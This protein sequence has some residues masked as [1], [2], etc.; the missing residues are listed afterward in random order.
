MNRINQRSA[1]NRCQQLLRGNQLLIAK[2]RKLQ[3][4]IAKLASG[5]QS[6]VAL[7]PA[8]TVGQIIGT[9][10]EVFGVDEWDIKS[11]KRHQ[12]VALARQ[13]AMAYTVRYCKVSASEAGRIFNRD[14]TTVVFAIN[15]INAMDETDPNIRAKLAAMRELVEAI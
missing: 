5:I 12:P 10:A 1:I 8:K 7:I 15:S 3:A 9:A 11:R 4:E 6:R 13:A 2:N 14:H